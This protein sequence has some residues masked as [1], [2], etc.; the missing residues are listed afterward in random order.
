MKHYCSITK[1]LLCLLN[2]SS[3][4]TAN[5]LEVFL[6]DFQTDNTMLPFLSDML[7]NLVLILLRMFIKS[8]IIE[9]AVTAYDLTKIDVEKKENQII[10]GIL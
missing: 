4:K 7:E 2:S 10:L 5:I 1:I 9:D 6:K 8:K 3:S